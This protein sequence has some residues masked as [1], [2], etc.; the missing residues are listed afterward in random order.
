MLRPKIKTFL[1]NPRLPVWMP[2][3]TVDAKT[4]QFYHNLAIP[5]TNDNRPNLLLHDLGNDPNLN[6]KI[7]FQSGAHHR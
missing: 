6:V 1:T 5:N 7:L 2:P 4:R 3:D